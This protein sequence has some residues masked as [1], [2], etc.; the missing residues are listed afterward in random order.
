MRTCAGSTGTRVPALRHNEYTERFTSVHQVTFGVSSAPSI[1]QHIMEQLL[2]GIPRVSVYID[3]VL[4]TGTTEEDHL[5]TV[6]EVLSCIEHAGLKLKCSKCFFMLP[7]VE[8]LGHVVSA[9]GLHP[10]KE[11]S[12]P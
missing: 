11:K 12:E 1:F 5:C 8:F 3:D 7:S 6:E 2:Q 4:I 9:D 10:M